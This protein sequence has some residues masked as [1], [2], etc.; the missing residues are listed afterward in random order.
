MELAVVRSAPHHALK[1][2]EMRPL[3]FATHWSGPGNGAFFVL[4]PRSCCI[5]GDWSIPKTAQCVG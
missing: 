2:A 3:F 5:A 4:I 1:V